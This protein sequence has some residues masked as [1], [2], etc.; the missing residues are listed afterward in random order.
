MKHHIKT[1]KKQT[2]INKSKVTEI[3][4]KKGVV[5][6]WS[7]KGQ[8]NEDETRLLAKLT[9]TKHIFKHIAILPDFH[10]SGILMNGSVIPTRDYIYV[11]AIGGDIGC[12]MA[13]LELP[14]EITDIEGREQELYKAL[15]DAV[16]T[17]RRTWSEILQETEQL[18]VFDN[19]SELLTNKVIKKLQQQM[20]TV[21]DGNHFLEIQQNAEG[22]LFM[23][24]HT[25]S[26]YLGQLINEFYLKNIPEMQNNALYAVE[27]GSET[28][29][30]FIQDHGLAVEY[31][32]EN[33]RMIIK[34]ALEAL[35]KFLAP[36]WDVEDVLQGLQDMPHNY[37]AT[38]QFDGQEVIIHRKGAQKVEK[39]DMGVVPGDMGNTT[40]IV[41]GRGYPLTFNS[42]SHG[43]GRKMSR[44]EALNAINYEQFLESVEDIACR[45]DRNV[46]DEAPQAYKDISQVMKYQKEIVKIV[47]KL[48]PVINVKG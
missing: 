3:Q 21:G 10:I 39:G 14:L 44:G 25:G 34:I 12:G 4:T 2:K 16:P 1:E 48:T 46:L 26:R 23:L 9:K 11:N 18:E 13:F 8:I 19:S 20:G 29:R 47:E 32:A 27:A 28:G 15:Y 24:V 42:C 17:G 35:K 38:E 41:Q 31:A 5:K 37:I 45:T 30:K 7:E 40:Y 36:D 22:R 6:V 43:A 33:R